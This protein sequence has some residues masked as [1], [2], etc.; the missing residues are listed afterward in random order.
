MG[1]ARA[2]PVRNRLAAVRRGCT[3]A[4]PSRASG[5]PALPRVFGWLR[6]ARWS[7]TA[8]RPLYRAP[9]ATHRASAARVRC[10]SRSKR[11]LLAFASIHSL[12]RA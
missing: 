2:R 12:A 10:I 4:R 6:P 3:G 1:L 7:T 11:G 5:T 9:A 8:G